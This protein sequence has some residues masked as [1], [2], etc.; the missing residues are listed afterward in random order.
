LEVKGPEL[1]RLV[2]VII[3]PGLVLARYW[4]G[5]FASSM[6]VGVVWLV[7]MA[8]VLLLLARFLRMDYRQFVQN[9]NRR[10]DS[11]VSFGALIVLEIASTYLL[12]GVSK[13]EVAQY[14]LLGLVVGGALATGGLLLFR[15]P[16][17]QRS[18]S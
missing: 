15:S 14:V 16:G 7:A 9:I 17:N 18:H 1:A 6:L 2:A 5:D 4:S 12:V 8:F 3:S 11:N 13:G 10:L